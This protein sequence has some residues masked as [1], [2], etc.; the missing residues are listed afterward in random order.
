MSMTAVAVT[1]DGSKCAVAWKDVRTGSPRVWWS[2]GPAAKFSK[3]VALAEG[4]TAEQNHP[5][6]ALDATGTGWLAWEEGRGRD[7]LVRLRSFP[8][9]DPRDLADASQGVPA[10]PVLALGPGWLVVAWET[11][12]SGGDRVVA[13]VVEGKGR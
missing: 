2:E 10:F 5:A 4:G 1:P 9:G 3:D 11:S 8:G 6:L 13:R 12:G 7:A